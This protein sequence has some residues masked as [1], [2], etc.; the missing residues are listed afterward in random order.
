MKSM[1]RPWHY[2]SLLWQLNLIKQPVSSYQVHALAWFST[3]YRIT[4]VN[5]GTTSELHS[6]CLF[7]GRMPPALYGQYQRIVDCCGSCYGCSSLLLFNGCNKRCGSP[8]LQDHCLLYNYV[9]GWCFIP[10]VN[11]LNFHHILY[12]LKIKDVNS[13]EWSWCIFLSVTYV[14]KYVEYVIFIH[15]VGILIQIDNLTQ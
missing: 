7:R 8:S 12:Q 1:S 9:H 2:S 3:L 15:F 4:S 6:C 11:K 10:G 5:P 13:I 14:W